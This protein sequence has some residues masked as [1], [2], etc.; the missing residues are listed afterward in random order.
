MV[1]NFRLVSD[2]SDGSDAWADELMMCFLGAVLL[3]NIGMDANDGIDYLTRIVGQR[4]EIDIGQAHY[5]FISTQPI[6]TSI[7][8]EVTAI[9]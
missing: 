3:L 5:R 8:L 7:G 6:S 4:E 9:Q 1:T 2:E